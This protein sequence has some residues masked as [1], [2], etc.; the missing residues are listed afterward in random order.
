MEEPLRNLLLLVQ[1]VF[2]DKLSVNLISY[3]FINLLLADPFSNVSSN[4]RPEHIIQEVIHVER[5]LR[6]FVLHTLFITLHCLI[7][8]RSLKPTYNL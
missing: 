4:L 2:Q 8:L 6:S 7:F 1:S 3:H 5:F